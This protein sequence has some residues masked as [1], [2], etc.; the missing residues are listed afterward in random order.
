[1]CGSSISLGYLAWGSIGSAQARLLSEK[2]E[3]E[4][5]ERE[6]PV[7]LCNSFVFTKLPR[8]DF[9]GPVK[10]LEMSKSNST[11]GIALIRGFLFVRKH[12]QSSVLWVTNALSVH[13]LVSKKF[14]CASSCNQIWQLAFYGHTLHQEVERYEMKLSIV[15]IWSYE[16]HRSIE[17]RL[18]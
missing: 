13:N 3:E 10:D 18:R 16:K 17:T 12:S 15:K 5:K 14:S 4:S 11:Q 6:W 7:L 9:V 1:M 8:N 2:A